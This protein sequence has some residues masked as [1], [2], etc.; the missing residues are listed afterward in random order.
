MIVPPT[1]LQAASSESSIRRPEIVDLFRDPHLLARGFVHKV[2][3]PTEDGTIEERTL[4]GSP[5]RLSASE[6]PITRAPRLG[7][8]TAEVLAEELG[9]DAS[10][11]EELRTQGVIA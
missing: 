2:Q 8:H 5:L 11:I 1:G 7:E 9:L 3:Q 10:A 4:L 6:V